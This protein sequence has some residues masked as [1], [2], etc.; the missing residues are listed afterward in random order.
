MDREA[1]VRAAAAV[2]LGGHLLAEVYSPT[3]RDQMGKPK[4]AD[5]TLDRATARRL[6]PEF[7]FPLLEETWLSGRH[8]LQM[9]ARRS[10]SV[11]A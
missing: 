1:F 8:V 3:H 7:E 4:N 11:A 2:R 9:I 6:L 10:L 5:L